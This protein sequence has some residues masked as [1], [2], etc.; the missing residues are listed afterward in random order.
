MRCHLR[1]WNSRKDLK[2]LS[3]RKRRKPRPE[4]GLD[5]LICF[6]FAKQRLGTVNFPHGAVQT[7]HQDLSC[8]TQS[9]SGPQVVRIWSRTPLILRGTKPSNFNE[10]AAPNLIAASIYDKYSVGSSIRP[11]SNLC[12]FTISSVI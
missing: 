5:W 3:H 2:K 12:C 8:F 1:A 7:F 6:K 10:R 9:T 11:I 4:S